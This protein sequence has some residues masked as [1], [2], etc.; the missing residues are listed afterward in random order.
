MTGIFLPGRSC[1]IK[2]GIAGMRSAGHLLC[3]KN[4]VR[5][6]SRAAKNIADLLFL[7]MIYRLATTADIP[8]IMR[9]RFAVKENTLSRPGLVTDADCDE[10]INHRGKGWVCDVGNKIAGFAI[11][12]LQDHNIWALFVEPGFDG[13]GIG[14][15]LHNDMLDWYFSQTN[16][17]V[18]LSTSP[19]T[20]AEQFYRK[21][22]WMQTGFTGSGEIRFEM[23]AAKWKGLP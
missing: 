18:W 4:M 5:S 11:A 22:G 2:H 16:H 12:D 17:T 7:R 1:S 21:A 10:Y 6:K 14:K 8:E 23:T 3:R 15:R 20:K 13:L 9:V 19:G